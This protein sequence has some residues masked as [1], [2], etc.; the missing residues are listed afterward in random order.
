MAWKTGIPCQ[1]AESFQNRETKVEI[2]AQKLLELHENWVSVAAAKSGFIKTRALWLFLVSAQLGEVSLFTHQK[3]C[4]IL[5]SR[6]LSNN[7]RTVF[8]LTFAAITHETPTRNLQ[9]TYQ[10]TKPRSPLHSGD[11][12]LKNG[13]NIQEPHFHIIARKPR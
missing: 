9:N 10:N 5:V 7:T 2:F 13:Q 1:H 6:F 8:C 12:N 4:Y 11:R 3:T